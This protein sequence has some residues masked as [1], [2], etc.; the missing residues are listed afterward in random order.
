[1]R[2]H[3]N[4]LFVTTQGAYLRKE[5]EAVAIKI[6]GKTALRLPLHHLG[7]ICCFGRVGV[8]PMLMGRCAEAGVSITF[9]TQHGRM[10]ARV[11]GFTPGNVLLRREQYRRADVLDPSVANNCASVAQ[12]IVVAKLLNSRSVLM[13]AVRDYPDAA[14]RPELERAVTRLASAVGHARTT[15]DID[16]LRGVEGDGASTYF[17]VFGHLVT[18]GE[19]AWAFTGRNRRPPRD[20]INALLSFLYTLLL[21]DARS[22][23]E[24]AGLDSQV[25]FL[26]RDRPGR[27]S[28]ALDLM[29]EF[30]AFLCDRLTLSLVNRSQIDSS[31]FETTP[32]GGVVM[33]DAARKTVLGAYQKR[34]LEEMMHPFIVGERVSVGLLVHLQ[35]RLL[36]RFLRGDLDAYPAFLWK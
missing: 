19:A 20:P 4:T 25:G 33:T 24:A 29:E 15:T 2:Q 10:L 11:S 26:H 14:G 21:H 18:R 1:V 31:A 3:L 22:A 30:R 8:S 9:L 28:L 16:Q 27:P 6:D 12:P 7:G 23:L 35:A 32:V 5:G 36:A 34:K 13:R 17:S